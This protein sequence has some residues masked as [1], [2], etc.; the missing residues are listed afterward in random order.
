[1]VIPFREEFKVPDDFEPPEFLVAYY[2]VKV[3]NHLDMHI[4]EFTKHFVTTEEEKWIDFIKEHKT[5]LQFIEKQ[6]DKQFYLPKAF[7]TIVT[8]DA[9]LTSALNEFQVV[10]SD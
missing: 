2:K 6:Q 9:G 7:V 10:L 1:M 3:A 5:A 8:K 4:S